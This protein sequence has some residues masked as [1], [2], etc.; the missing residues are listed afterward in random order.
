MYDGAAVVL[1]PVFGSIADRAGPCPVMIGGLVAFAVIVVVDDLGWLWLARLGQG[2]GLPLF[3]RRQ[4]PRR[5]DEPAGEAGQGVRPLL[6]PQQYR[7]HPGSAA[8]WRR[9]VG[10][11][12]SL[13]F[14][15]RKVLA[16]VAP[17]VWAV[18]E[19]PV[20]PRRQTS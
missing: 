11:R 8:R 7:L 4:C 14:A 6:V 5:P 19:V 18:C 13:P 3:T 16:C 15:V 9:R 12:L 2:R 17:V 20:V 10:R 1:K